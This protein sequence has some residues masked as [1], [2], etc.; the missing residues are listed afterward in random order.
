MD[1]TP[2]IECEECG[3]Q[4]DCSELLCHPEDD[5]KAVAESRFNVC[6]ECD[7]VD[8]FADYED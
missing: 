6:P 8:C 4:G 2:E 3:W 5:D 1:D 7:A